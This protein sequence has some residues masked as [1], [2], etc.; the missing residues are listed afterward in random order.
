MGPCVRRDDPLG[1]V[2]NRSRINARLNSTIWDS[3]AGEGKKRCGEACQPCRK[4]GRVG[5]YARYAYRYLNGIKPSIQEKSCE[6]ELGTTGVQLP[7]WFLL[8]A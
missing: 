1:I 6:V 7:F 8:Q 4:W 5:R 3:P 2:R